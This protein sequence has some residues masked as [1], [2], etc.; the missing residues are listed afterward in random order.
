MLNQIIM[1]TT[2]KKVLSGKCPLCK[3]EFSTYFCPNCGIP[4]STNNNM[5]PEYKSFKEFQ[6]CDKCNTKNPFHAKYCRNCGEDITLHAKDKN[7]HGWVDLGLS[8]LWSTETIKGLYIWNHSK[9]EVYTFSDMSSYLGKDIENKDI[10]TIKWGVKWRTPTKNEFEELIKKC[11]WNKI[12]ISPSNTHAFKVTG[13]NGNSIIIPVTGHAGCYRSDSA[14]FESEN[15]H[16]E[17]SFWT[18]TEEPSRLYCAYA[19]RYIGYNGFVRTLTAREKKE[20]MFKIRSSFE[21]ISIYD[22]DFEQKWKQK[23]Q[24]EEEERKILQAMGDDWNERQDNLKKD[25]ERRHTL[26]LETPIEFIYD[27]KDFRKNTICVRRK[28]EGYAI[29]PVADKKWQGEL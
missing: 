3:K 2:P 22:D 12:L 21:H 17:C 27:M 20:Q 15:I 25:N 4:L 5:R 23:R 13:P 19:F 1:A 28:N 9:E 11:Q 26:W 29:R 14:P 10:A 6:L 16:S 18:S 24:R 7:G 8:V